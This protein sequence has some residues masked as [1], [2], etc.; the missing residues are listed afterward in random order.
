MLLLFLVC[1]VLSVSYKFIEDS[2]ELWRMLALFS[3]GYSLRLW[4]CE[5]C[6]WMEGGF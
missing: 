5:M 1:L 3:N 6:G 2:S 4:C